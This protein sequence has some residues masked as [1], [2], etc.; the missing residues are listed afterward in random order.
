LAAEP[1]DVRMKLGGDQHV[2]L[3]IA[4]SVLRNE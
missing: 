4:L 1:S 3:L 2:L